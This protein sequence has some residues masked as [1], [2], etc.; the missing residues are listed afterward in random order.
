LAAEK[1]TGTAID[2]F[3]RDWDRVFDRRIASAIARGVSIASIRH[4]CLRA[5]DEFPLKNAETNDV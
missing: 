4:R 2:D 5:V 1:P 3:L